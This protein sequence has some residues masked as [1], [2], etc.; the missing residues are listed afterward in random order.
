MKKKKQKSNRKIWWRI[1]KG[2]VKI[3]KKKPE[4][5]FMGE[6]FC[7]RS[8]IL[9]N[10]VGTKCPLTLEYFFP[11]NFR[12]WGTHEMTE[13]MRSMCHYLQDVFYPIKKG[14]KKVPSKIIGFL[15]TPI[16]TYIYA[17]LN[18]I[19]T[20]KDFRFMTTIKESIKTL[21]K[22]ENIIIF[23]EDSTNG[24]QDVLVGFHGGFTTLAS[25]A[26]KEG[27]DLPIYVMYYQKKN[28]R[29]VVGK[30][31]KYSELVN[32]GMTKDEMCEYLCN[33][34]N[35]LGAYQKDIGNK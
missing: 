20:Y 10:H 4:W 30:P 27:M 26:L 11:Y 9:C 24:Y 13:G 17:G 33:E 18:L 32:K 7:E 16:T 34:C 6:E 35:L 8:I 25:A 23:P 28:H 1:S 12:F 21:K 15:G 2:L 3:T 14:W 5:V 22:N 29:F 19:P 31:V